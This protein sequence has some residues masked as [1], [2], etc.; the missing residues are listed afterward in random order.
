MGNIIILD[1]S[2]CGDQTLFIFSGILFNSFQTF[3]SFENDSSIIKSN[4][5]LNNNITINELK[6]NNISN[7]ISPIYL[8]YLSDLIEKIRLYIFNGYASIRFYIMHKDDLKLGDI[9]LEN[10]INTIL[11]EN[12]NID[13]SRVQTYLYYHLSSFLIKRLNEL[14]FQNDYIE[15][16]ICDNVYNLSNTVNTTIWA[17]GNIASIQKD[18]KE[19]APMIIEKVHNQISSNKHNGFRK[20]DFFDSKLYI[21]IQLND[22]LSNFLLNSIR[23]I[24]FD[25]KANPISSKYKAKYDFLSNY[26][27]LRGLNINDLNLQEINCDISSA[28]VFDAVLGKIL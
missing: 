9:D 2:K 28:S 3:L 1:E 4:I 12:T 8:R 6:G 16:A 15:S 19:I 23:Y 11:E 27:D 21:T 10:V 5:M 14:P 17:R 25:N 26:I 7:V 24:Y 18:I 13:H 22:I 20:L